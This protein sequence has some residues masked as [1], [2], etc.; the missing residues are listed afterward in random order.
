MFVLTAGLSFNID[1]M[2]QS[3]GISTQLYTPTSVLHPGI[4]SVQLA[5]TVR[6]ESQTTKRI[7]SAIRWTGYLAI[8]S[9]FWGKVSF[10]A[11]A[12]SVL[13]SWKLNL[14]PFIAAHPVAPTSWSFA[15]AIV[16]GGGGHESGFQPAGFPRT[17][18][19]AKSETVWWVVTGWHTKGPAWGLESTWSGSPQQSPRNC[20]SIGQEGEV[21][22]YNL[23]EYFQMTHP[24]FL[25]LWGSGLA[26]NSTALERNANPDQEKQTLTG[27]G[28]IQGHHQMLLQFLKA[29]KCWQE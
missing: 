17:F 4:D 1:Q 6:T 28:I 22:A 29:L 3:K 7:S 16:A 15:S 5:S 21:V 27:E 26:Q 25:L 12:L 11:C 9:C 10:L 19:Q 24:I 20:I 14:S 13:Q 23:R 2:L 8:T 18:L